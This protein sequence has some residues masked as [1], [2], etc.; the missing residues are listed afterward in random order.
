MTLRGEIYPLLKAADWPYRDLAV[1]R[2]LEVGQKHEGLPWVAFGY[3]RPDEFEILTRQEFER[4]GLSL[5]ELSRIALENLARRKAGWHPLEGEAAEAVGPRA[6]A[7]IGDELAAERVLDR[8]F[9]LRAQRRLN[10]AG[11]LAAI[12]R[13]GFLVV[14]PLDAPKAAILNLVMN[15]QEQFHSGASAPIT[16][17]V[18]IV[19]DGDLVGMVDL[20]TGG[21]AV[22]GGERDGA[23][24][25]AGAG[26]S[27]ETSLSEHLRQGAE[28][29]RRM[30]PA[31]A[32]VSLD[33]SVQSLR[34]LDKKA[35]Q[36]RR[37]YEALPEAEEV[38]GAATLASKQG[39]LFMLGAYVGEVVRGELPGGRWRQEEGNLLAWA[40]DWATGQGEVR[41]WP[42]QRAYEVLTG[43][44]RKGFHDLWQEAERAWRGLG[45]G[46][47]RGG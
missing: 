30:M 28:A 10:A 1:I 12:P 24:G 5:E 29:C 33:G 41:L 4:L 3:D 47:G 32:Q 23:G 18:F 20:K 31:L 39:L 27:E 2:R 37:V 34:T 15:A 11:L 46:G 16:P 7:C 14:I 13:R 9:M 42:F 38:Q 25:Q 43:R 40:V 45:L 19:K 22:E 17:L 8:D 26:T 44:T 6:L 35:R 21:S 36:L